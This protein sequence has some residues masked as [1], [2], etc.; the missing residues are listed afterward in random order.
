MVGKGDKINIWTDFWIP[1]KRHPLL[2]PSTGTYNFNQVC[3]LITQAKTLD[4]TKLNTCFDRDTIIK[5]KQIQ[6][7]L[8][9]REDT[10]TWT[11]NRNGKFTVNSL[12]NNLNGNSNINTSWNMIWNMK[13]SPSI[14][15]FTWKMAHSILPNSMRVDAIL[16]YINTTCLL[17][18][19][20]DE[21][22]THLFLDYNFA[23]QVWNHL[24]FSMDY[25]KNDSHTCHDWINSWCTLSERN[26]I[27]MGRAELRSTVTWHFWKA[28]CGKVFEKKKIKTV[29]IHLFK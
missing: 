6:I 4:E 26:G 2:K 22:L 14:K 9:N 8:D 5:I 3:D 21:S 28:R 10:T 23:C 25:V 27:K 15:L 19:E 1:D 11:L 16:P 17:C 18:N 7:P 20:H 29:G 24:N 13:V 12:Y